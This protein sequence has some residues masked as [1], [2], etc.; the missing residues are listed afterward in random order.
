MAA[1]GYSVGD[2]ILAMRS[3]WLANGLN[4]IL[5][6]MLIF[7]IGPFP[8][9]GVEGAAIATNIGRGTGVIFQLYILL[10]G[11]SVIR[12]GWENIKIRIKN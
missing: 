2:G 9:F 6:P 8:E 4:M 1:S 12:I 11:R 10:R 7:G 3:L 5:D